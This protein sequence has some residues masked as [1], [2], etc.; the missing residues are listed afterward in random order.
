MDLGLKLEGFHGLCRRY[1]RSGM[2][3]VTIEIRITERLSE[4][5]AT[6]WFGSHFCV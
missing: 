1:C 4:S 3:L 5:F 2:M 6:Y